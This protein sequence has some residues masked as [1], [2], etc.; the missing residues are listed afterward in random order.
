M[1]TQD[2]CIISC[3]F[4]PSKY[5]TKLL[6]FKRFIRGLRSI[7]AEYRIIECVLGSL[8]ERELVADARTIHV[9]SSDAIWQ[10]E[11]L[12]NL[13]LQSLPRQVSKVV[14]LDCDVIF[15]NSDWLSLTSAALDRVLVLQPFHIAVRLNKEVTAYDGVGEAYTSFAL[16]CRDNGARKSDEFAAHGHTGFA[17]AA[18]R[19]LLD[20]HGF[21]DVCLTGEADHLMAH[22]MVGDLNHECINRIVGKAGIY[23]DHFE[24]WA[25]PFARE[26][27][28]NIGF[29]PG[30]VLHLWHGDLKDRKYHI[31]SQELLTFDFQPS[32][33]LRVN[34]SGT[35][36]W[37]NRK[38]N[39]QRWSTR[40]FQTRNEDGE[41]PC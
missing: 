16:Q 1:S 29:V 24:S 10:K 18:R 28:G 27:D 13:V 11:R 8:N 12:L 34:A 33:D 40:F 38:I 15:Q 20:R 5:K 2:I 21:Y 35:W 19:E 36:E 17:W 23:R 32:R 31:Q 3:F 4:N 25:T 37:A 6:N 26:V 9:T 30:R 41:G 7:G 39:L 14:W 22:A